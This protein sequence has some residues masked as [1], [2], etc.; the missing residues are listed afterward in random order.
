MGMGIQFIDLSD[1]ASQVLDQHLRT[2]SSLPMHVA[3]S[4]LRSFQLGK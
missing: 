3:F 2:S 1:D 4:N